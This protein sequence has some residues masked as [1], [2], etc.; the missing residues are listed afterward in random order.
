M[1]W[2]S[3]RRSSIRKALINK[4]TVPTAADSFDL[5]L[6]PRIGEI[7]DLAGGKMRDLRGINHGCA[8]PAEAT[9]RRINSSS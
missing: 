9:F 3:S 4:L 2:I 5:S 6:S 8:R 7:H 1:I